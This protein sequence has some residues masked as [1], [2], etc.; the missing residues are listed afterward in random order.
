MLLCC[1]AVWAQ[2]QLVCVY[3]VVSFHYVQWALL[4]AG[5]VYCYCVLFGP[6]QAQLGYLLLN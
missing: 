4:R 1:L 6:Q 3:V 2:E 5:A